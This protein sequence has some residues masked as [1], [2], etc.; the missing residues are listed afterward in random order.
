MVEKP[1]LEHIRISPKKLTFNLVDR[2]L[3]AWYDEGLL[4]KHLPPTSGVESADMNLVKGLSK[5]LPED[6]KEALESTEFVNVFGRAVQ[7][8]DKKGPLC[9]QYLYVW[10]YQA[11]PLHEADYEPIYVYIENDQRYAIYDLVH[12]CTRRIDL[13]PLGQDGPGLHV[14]PGWH[15]FL[16]ATLKS[17]QIDSGLRVIPLSDQH[18]NSWWNIPHESTR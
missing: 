17:S 2:N 8:K 11:V 15:S 7:R 10:D 6:T 4:K 14:V 5:Y 16:P 3:V 13:G 9:L 1:H 12:Y 18:L